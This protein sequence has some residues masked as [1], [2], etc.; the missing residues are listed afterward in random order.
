[1]PLVHS[2][3]ALAR[4]RTVAGGEA[5]AAS[6]ALKRFTTAIRGPTEHPDQR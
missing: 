5:D 2:K 6:R 4:S 1:M 3:K